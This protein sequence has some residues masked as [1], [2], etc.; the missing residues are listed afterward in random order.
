MSWYYA[1][2]D[3]R[4]G[5]IEDPA[6]EALVGAGAITP[7]TLVWREGFAD[8]VPYSQVSQSA[9]VPSPAAAAGRASFLQ[10]PAGVGQACSQCGQLFAVDEMVSYE[11]RFICAGCKPAFF[12]RIK[13]GASVAGT[14]VYAGFWI[15]FVAKVI[16]LILLQF[17]AFAIGF[18]AGLAF[19]NNESV[20]L[21]GGG[22][23]LVF[24]VA[25]YIYFVGKFGATPGKMA[26]KLE[27]IRPDGSPMTYGRAAGRF[28]AEVVTWFT[29]SIGYLMAAFDEEKRA[30]HDRIADTRV[31]RKT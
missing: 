24:Q 19:R 9:A 20:G 3:V 17:G 15:R 13:E 25:Y 8:W 4:H 11:G 7:D 28:F 16:D 2:S 1:E 23:A 27:I 12:Q 6:F 22:L 5:P 29:I 30:L 31:V 26:V 21:I 14:R 10:R 18:V